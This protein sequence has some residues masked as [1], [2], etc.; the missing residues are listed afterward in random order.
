MRMRGK[1]GH[2]W[3]IVELAF[4]SGG[5][6]KPCRSIR[7][8]NIFRRFHARDKAARGSAKKMGKDGGRA[9]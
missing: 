4:L 1:D 2:T 6:K 7:C 5:K 9:S 3:K 8:L